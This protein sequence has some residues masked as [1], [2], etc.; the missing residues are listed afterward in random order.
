MFSTLLWLNKCRFSS[1]PK[2]LICLKIMIPDDI[3]QK[4]N[5]NSSNFIRIKKEFF[6]Y[7]VKDISKCIREHW[8]PI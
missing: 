3:Q 1:Y 6:C 2:I 8:E 4:K 7:E 5:Q